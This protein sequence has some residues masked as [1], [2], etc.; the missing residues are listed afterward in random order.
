MNNGCEIYE[1]L[2]KTSW[3]IIAFESPVALFQSTIPF[4]HFYL[5]R[6]GR[7]WVVTTNLRNW[8]IVC[9][10]CNTNQ[11]LPRTVSIVIV[12]KL[13]VLYRIDLIIM[14][15]WI[16]IVCAG[17]VQHRKSKKHVCHVPI[18]DERERKRVREGTKN[19]LQSA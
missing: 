9:R 11:H 15:D 16:G 3:K 13:I 18:C 6:E 5:Q 1:S 2:A 10:Y 7:R 8:P 19:V 4:S 12:A 14:A 17:K